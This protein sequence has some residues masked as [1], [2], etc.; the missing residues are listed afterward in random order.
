MKLLKM[1][2]TEHHFPVLLYIIQ[3][4]VVLTFESVDK[5]A[6]VKTVQ[7]KATSQYVHAMLFVTE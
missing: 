5:I 1:K 2:A 7:I 4:K 6:S 3:Y